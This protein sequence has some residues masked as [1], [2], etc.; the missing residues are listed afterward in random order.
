VL[1]SRAHGL[2]QQ[3]INNIEG[4]IALVERRI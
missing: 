3:A 2:D 1:V 4:R